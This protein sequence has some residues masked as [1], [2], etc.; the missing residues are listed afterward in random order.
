VIGFLTAKISELMDFLAGAIYITALQTF[1]SKTLTPF[2]YCISGLM[3]CLAACAP[4]P[5][6]HSINQPATVIPTLDVTSGE[7]LCAAVQTYWDVNWPLTL[8]ALEALHRLKTDCPGQPPTQERLYRAYVTY[9]TLLE[10]RVRS[11]EAVQAFQTALTF[12]TAGAEA[13]AG[14]QRLNVFTPQ[15]PPQCDPAQVEQLLASVPAYVP[16]KGE[17]VRVQDQGFIVNEQP[18]RVYGVNYYPRDFP[19]QRFLTAT[20]PD[21]LAQEFD[22]LSAA[23]INTLRLYLRHDLLFT[24]I[25]DGAV[26]IPERFAIL[27]KFIQAAAGRNFR[28]MLTLNDSPDL[29]VYPLYSQPEHSTEQIRYLVSRYRDESAIIAWDLRE[30]GDTDYLIG[31]FDRETVLDWLAQ[32]AIMI[33]ETDPNH[34]ITASWTEDAEATI[35]YVDVVSFQGFANLDDLRQQ[36][37]LLRSR[38][39]KP[40]LLSR[41]GYSTAAMSETEQRD[42]I[43]EV[44]QAAQNNQLAGWMLWTAFDFPLT[45]ACEE[46]NCP[47]PDSPDYHYGLW[48]TSYF[49]KLALEAV[50]LVT[51]AP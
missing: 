32:T 43:Y 12:N 4:N 47:A 6:N 38:T 35:P 26:P 13:V 40:L 22:L 8:R 31:D 15:P 23:G 17:F 7:S 29:S 36:I 20:N 45:A 44:L 28:L 50:K 34:L 39:D 25:G 2:K 37:A 9:G 24:C 5:A 18:F 51:G 16:G 46:P 3:L 21:N 27:D 48:N 30:G 14:L 49:P 42:R 19:Y 1:A 10:G 33:R 41:F 11:A